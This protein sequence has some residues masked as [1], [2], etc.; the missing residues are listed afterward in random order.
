MRTYLYY[1]FL[2][3]SWPK[4]KLGEFHYPAAKCLKTLIERFTVNMF[5][6]LEGQPNII[7]KHVAIIVLV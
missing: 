5:T 1:G 7:T 3:V 4:R 2:G 6:S